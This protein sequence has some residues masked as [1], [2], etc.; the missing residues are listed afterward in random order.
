MHYPKGRGSSGGSSRAPC[1]KDEAQST[2]RGWEGEQ[3]SYL[4]LP[5]PLLLCGPSVVDG[6]SLWLGGFVCL[7]DVG[8]KRKEACSLP[9]L[10]RHQPSALLRSFQGAVHRPGGGPKVDAWKRGCFQVPHP[11]FS[12]GIR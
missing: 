12:A 1:D 2:P 7:G 3:Q 6:S 10:P 5:L 8:L 4:E 9:A 11:L